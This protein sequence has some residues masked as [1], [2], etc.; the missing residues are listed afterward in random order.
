MKDRDGHVR[1]HV[2]A[3]DVRTAPQGERRHMD[4]MD[5]H[6]RPSHVVARRR[7][8]RQ[9]RDGCRRDSVDAAVHSPESVKALKAE[10]PRP[11]DF[12]QA[13]PLI[14]DRALAAVQARS[15]QRFPVDERH[16]RHVSG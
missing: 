11:G 10:I 14:G 1:E 5:C 15:A 9:R 13:Q 16:V 7:A 2:V 8:C 12:Y 6:N 4:C 3:Y